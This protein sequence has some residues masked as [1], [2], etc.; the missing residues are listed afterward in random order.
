M[1]AARERRFPISLLAPSSSWT[2]VKSRQVRNPTPGQPARKPWAAK[3]I[4]PLSSPLSQAA[5]AILVRAPPTP[6]S[7]I[8]AVPSHSHAGRTKLLL[9][10]PRSSSEEA[11][12]KWI[13]LSTFQSGV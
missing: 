6:T 2:R 12:R 9:G 7:L 4:L 10:A 3:P 11:V 13:N 5:K 8:S 1:E